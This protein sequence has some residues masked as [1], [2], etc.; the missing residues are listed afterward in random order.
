[1]HVESKRH[2]DLI[3]CMV[4]C[5]PHSQ[6][7]A[8]THSYRISRNLPDRSQL[9]DTRLINANDMIK[10]EPWRLY[11]HDEIEDCISKLKSVKK[12]NVGNLI[13]HGRKLSIR[14]FNTNGCNCTYKHDEENN[15]NLLDESNIFFKEVYEKYIND[16]VIHYSI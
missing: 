4:E 9:F 15:K 1:M 3:N 13:E 16:I 6:I 2:L 5:F 11:L 12:I 7:F 8:T 10:A 14:C